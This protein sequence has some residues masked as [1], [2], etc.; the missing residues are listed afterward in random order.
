MLCTSLVDEFKDC[1]CFGEVSFFNVSKVSE[2]NRAIKF[3][4]K[5]KKTATETFKMFKSAYSEECILRTS[6]FGQHKRFKEGRESLQD[7]EWKGCPSTSRTEEF[8]PEKYYKW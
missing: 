2:W 6:V 4:V 3:C 1:S 7:D 5:L 8:M